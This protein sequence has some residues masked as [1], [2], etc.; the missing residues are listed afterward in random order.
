MVGF[1]GFC[2]LAL[3]T[4]DASILD[5]KSNVKM[6]LLNIDIDYTSFLYIGP[7]LIVALSFYI[8]ILLAE[9][10]RNLNPQTHV[11]GSADMYS[12]APDIFNIQRHRMAAIIYNCLF[13]W[14]PIFVLLCF[15]LKWIPQQRDGWG[16]LFSTVFSIIAIPVFLWIKIRRCPDRQRLRKNLVSWLVLGMTPLYLSLVF[17]APIT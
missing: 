6:P 5:A 4:P 1:S 12:M 13:Y 11:A 2:L 7:M 9:W 10:F 15:A 8:H 16:T 17:F 14:I 3:A